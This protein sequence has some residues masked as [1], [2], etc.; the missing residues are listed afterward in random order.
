M[1]WTD[2]FEGSDCDSGLSSV[3]VQI[4]MCERMCRGGNYQDGEEETVTATGAG[5]TILYDAGRLN[6]V[7]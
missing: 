7:E 3:V 1:S 5:E 2:C 6:D 4:R